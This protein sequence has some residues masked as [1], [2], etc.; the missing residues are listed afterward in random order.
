[1]LV[2]AGCGG[3]DDGPETTAA[4]QP[5]AAEPA[6]SGEDSAAP[7][8]GDGRGGVRLERLGSFTAPLHVAQPPG[9]RRALFVV[10]QGG[11][12][13]RVAPNG[14]EE[15]FLDI[16][17]EVIAGGEQGLLSVAFAPD[18]QSSGRFYV[19]YTDTDGHTRVVEYRATDRG[20]VDADAGRELLRIEQPFAN[21][22]GGLVLFGPDGLLYI[23][24][25]DGGSAGDPRRNAL[26]LS[27]LLGK[28]LRIDPR[29]SDDRPYRIPDDNPFV[30]R[31]GARGEI[32]AY[33]LRNPWRYSFDRD[34]AAL[35]IADVG[36]DSLEEVNLVDRRTGAGA[37]F[38]WSAFEGT[39]R[40]NEDQTAPDAIPP[41]LTYPTA[42]GNCSVTGGYVV[43]DERLRSLYGRYLYGD[44]CRGEL[45]SFVAE[46]GRRGA[47]DRRL[48]PTIESLS[49]FGTD[50]AGRI[51]ATSLAGPV[52]R[53]EPD[54]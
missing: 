6:G 14:E 47:D 24:T 23:G 17:A 12:I 32:Y 42:D 46:P 21:H 8:V 4:E 31:D 33:G 44:F 37:S 1:M 39:E 41:V 13:V 54:G 22:N 19:D 29:P 38:G 26:D 50:N 15:T 35:S 10:E 27:T 48:G 40:F 53:L 52:Y 3:D 51:Y 25:G 9:E 2:I 11:R 49:S 20:E 45:R 34:T 7:P 36:Q 30:G 18:F 28:L 43:R 16:S 5:T